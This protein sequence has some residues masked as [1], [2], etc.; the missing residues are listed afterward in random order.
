MLVQQHRL[1]GEVAASAAVLLGHAQPQQPELA[2]LPV[3]LAVGVAL[4]LV[5]RRVGW[6]GDFAYGPP[7]MVGALLGLL[8][9]PQAVG[10][11]L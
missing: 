4:L 5:T 10:G 9:A 2:G 3:V 11:L 1:V 7:M 6:K 8:L